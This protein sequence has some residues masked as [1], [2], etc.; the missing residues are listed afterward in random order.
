MQ[1][2]LVIHVSIDGEVCASG[3]AAKWICNFK[4]QLAQA[5]L[6]VALSPLSPHDHFNHDL[7]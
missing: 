6:G 3:R 1:L 7:F 4:T 2:Y 5:H